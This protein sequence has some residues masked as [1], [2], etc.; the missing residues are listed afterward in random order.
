VAMLLSK[1]GVSVVGV[2]DHTGYRLNPEGFNAHRLAEYVKKHG[3]IKDYDSG[4][5]CT[6][7]EFFGAKADILIPAALHNQIGAAEAKAVQ[8]R[9]VLEGAN[10]PVMSDGETV[11]RERGI[12]V[13]PDILA[14]AGGVTVSYYEW[15]QNGRQECWELSE[16]D[17]RL[18]KAMRRTYRRVVEF[19]RER[20]CTLREAAYSLAL[21]RLIMVYKQRLIFP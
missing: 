7:A 3:A 4:D 14:N 6:R 17:E 21:I 20:G 12:D 19:S 8:A 5:A 1:L 9:V 11:L 2:G 18:D 10:G 15:V 13:V 16:V